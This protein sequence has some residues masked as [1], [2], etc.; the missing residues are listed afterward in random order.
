MPVFHLLLLLLR[1]PHRSK[2]KELR[3]EGRSRADYVALL[4]KDLAFVY[5]YSEF[6]MEKLFDLFGLK[7]IQEV[8][9]ANEVPRPITIRANTLKT[10]RRDL[11]QALINRGVNLEP[12]GPWSK[13]G[14]VVFDSNVPIGATPEYLAGH[15]MIQSASS[16]LACMALAPQLNERVLDMYVRLASFLTNTSKDARSAKSL[17]TAVCA[18]SPL[19]GFH[20]MM[21]VWGFDVWQLPC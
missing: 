16:F 6:M 8:L 5:G 18:L 21:L 19:L 7:E 17:R 1:G 11:A 10:R 15:Y 20:L 12:I 4:I 9:E 2:F 14:L 3:T 13:V